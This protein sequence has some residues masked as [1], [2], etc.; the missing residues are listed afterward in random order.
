M[1]GPRRR[2]CFVVE[3]LATRVIALGVHRKRSAT[4]WARFVVRT[5]STEPSPDAFAF[6]IFL[7]FP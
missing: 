5:G 6:V 2:P 7:A 3:A 1:N 4:M